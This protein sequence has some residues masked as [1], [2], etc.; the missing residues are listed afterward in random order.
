MTSGIVEELA[1]AQLNRLMEQHRQD[2]GGMQ[3]I[4]DQIAATPQERWS[5]GS[6]LDSIPL[7]K[8]MLEGMSEMVGV[9]PYSRLLDRLAQAKSPVMRPQTPFGW[10]DWAAGTA[11]EGLQT[12]LAGADMG[13]LAPLAVKGYVK[14]MKSLGELGQ[15]DVWR[16]SYNKTE[17]A[18]S[19]FKQLAYNPSIE[20]DGYLTEN[21]IIKKGYKILDKDSFPLSLNNETTI[22][23]RTGESSNEITNDALIKY[24]KYVD[25]NGVEKHA[26]I[27]LKQSGDI[28]SED[29]IVSLKPINNENIGNF[30]RKAESEYMD[31][32]EPVKTNA[33]NLSTDWKYWEGWYKKAQE[34]ADAHNEELKSKYIGNIAKLFDDPE[35]ID[36]AGV[37]RLSRK[38]ESKHRLSSGVAEDLISEIAKRQMP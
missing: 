26:Y 8:P 19:K 2:P 5:Q 6:M 28:L 31:L 32:K 30:F 13:A 38:M 22:N 37:M 35:Y 21:Q 1:K 23:L 34:L 18:K 12:G 27:R 29:S 20:S 3:S 14:G 15:V 16:G 7:A 33:N 10:A 11:A 36:S 17:I 25:E 24:Y 4:L 9:A